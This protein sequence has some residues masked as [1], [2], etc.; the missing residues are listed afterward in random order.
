VPLAPWPKAAFTPRSGD[1]RSERA[2]IRAARGGNQRIA[3]VGLPP[4]DHIHLVD[5]LLRNGLVRLVVT[6]NANG[7]PFSGK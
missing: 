5:A 4:G 6:H 3:E 7:A 2:E 1:L